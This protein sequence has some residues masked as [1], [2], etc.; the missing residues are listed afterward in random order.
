MTLNE[1]LIL[2]AQINVFL[3]FKCACPNCSLYFSAQKNYFS[4][5]PFVIFCVENI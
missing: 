1:S 3:R 4:T 2:S 5:Y